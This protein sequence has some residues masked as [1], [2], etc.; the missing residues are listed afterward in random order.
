MRKIFVGGLNRQTN[1]EDF[2]ALFSP[3]GEIIDLVII[4]DQG[5]R[6]SRGFGFITYATSDCVEKCFQSRPHNLDGKTL[7][8][9]RAI[10]REDNNSN[11]HQ[12]T[13]KLFIGGLGPEVSAED[14]KEYIRSRHEG[15]GE[16]V[17]FDI[18]K[19]RET[20]KN[21]A[22]GFIECD[23]EDFADRLTISE[24]Q[25][26]VNGRSMSLK[27]AEPKEGEYYFS[28]ILVSA[29][30]SNNARYSTSITF[31]KAVWGS[32]FKK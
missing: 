10:P 29:E 27:K 12:R 22:F 30:C 6:I 19:D 5:T 15:T 16:I 1:E 9:K 32:E 26:S 2:R 7:D 13:K 24:P 18:P 21:K 3:F 8:T 4:K 20:G 23:S 28:I 11:A 25:F 31:I 17:S 14:I